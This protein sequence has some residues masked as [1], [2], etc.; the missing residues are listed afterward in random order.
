MYVW[1]D[2]SPSSVTGSS[3]D[4][5]CPCCLS[6]HIAHGRIPPTLPDHRS[7]AR[8]AE[9]SRLPSARGCAC[10]RVFALSFICQC[11][12]HPH[13]KPLCILSHVVFPTFRNSCRGRWEVVKCKEA[14]RSLARGRPPT[15][16]LPGP[17]IL[18]VG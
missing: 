17:S 16:P 3:Q 9:C 14:C 15:A 10:A 6:T 12:Q 18:Q 13:S 1:Q 2:H 11:T 7:P 5:A 8:V 4:S